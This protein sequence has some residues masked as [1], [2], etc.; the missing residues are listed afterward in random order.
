MGT[1]VQSF[2]SWLGNGSK[3]IEEE[4]MNKRRANAYAEEQG[5]DVKGDELANGGKIDSTLIDVI[6][7]LE[8][9]TGFELLVTGGNDKYHQKIKSYTSNHTKGVAI[10][11]V[12]KDRNL[13][14]NIRSNRVKM[15]S[16]LIKLMT[17]GKYNKNG[18]RLG[19]I[20]EYDRP[21]AKA[22]G[23]HFHISITPDVR[24]R[25]GKECGLALTGI[26]SYKDI[27]KMIVDGT[28]A[29]Y[30]TTPEKPADNK[31]PTRKQVK[32]ARKYYKI[33]DPE[34]KNMLTVLYK[35]NGKFK[36][37]NRKGDRIAEVKIDGKDVMLTNKGGTPRNIT[38]NTV[39][40][41]F[42]K[43][44]KFA[45]YN[46]PISTPSGKDYIAIKQPNK[47]D[48]SGKRIL[49]KYSG[50]KASNINIIEQ[51]AINAGITNKN[52]II[53]ILSVVG[54]ETQFVP[55]SE[56]S[57]ATTDN[58]KIRSTFKTRLGQM[59]DEELNILKAN[60]EQFFNTVYGDMHGNV[61]KGDGWKYRGRGFNQITFKGNYE[62]YGRASGYDIVNNPDLLNQP[63][64]SADVM[65]KYMIS[66][67]RAARI[68]PNSF[69]NVDSAVQKFAAANT[70]WKANP[71]DAINKARRISTNFS[72]A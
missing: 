1:E 7:D 63:K 41:A 20:N 8:K 3:A 37:Y 55:R 52:S 22:T 67:F 60:P 33:W 72:I 70:G 21:T 27:R 16:A 11:V 59:P 35:G 49:H 12:T 36:V 62:K 57:Y 32:V 23:G 44:S 15:E 14:Q 18:L 29:D 65:I 10:D 61:A 47:K 50:T 9:E 2:D 34:N 4:A 39:G 58:N 51:A 19:A 25:D 28:G 38:N 30:P 42:V 6:A 53:G 24:R 46:K 69:T 43:V 40:N 48:T 26:K 31:K 17:S 68:D 13:F 71:A 5:I 66:K 64:V 45:H 54:K 56:I